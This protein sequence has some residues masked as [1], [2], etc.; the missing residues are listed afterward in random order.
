[1]E[2]DASE[3]A[4]CLKQ[5]LKRSPGNQTFL[6][7]I[8]KVVLT[9]IYLRELWT[10]VAPFLP[11]DSKNSGIMLIRITQFFSCSIDVGFDFENCDKLGGDE[12]DWCSSDGVD[13]ILSLGFGNPRKVSLGEAY[14]VGVYLS[15]QINPG[16]IITRHL[17][18]ALMQRW[19][20][21][22]QTLMLEACAMG[23]HSTG[24]PSVLDP[25]QIDERELHGLTACQKTNLHLSYPF[26][27]KACRHAFMIRE[28]SPRIIPSK[29]HELK[30][31]SNSGTTLFKDSVQDEECLFEAV[32][33]VDS[34]QDEECLFEAVTLVNV[35]NC[36]V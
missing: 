27:K 14:G 32:T 16:H 19:L 8:S 3:M 28:T 22:S 4:N 23:P 31:L 2:G 25:E 29:S 34:V 24:N 6:T 9:D 10:S 7:P 12:V 13:R 11:S 26:R 30:F 36:A 18:Y 20:H 15:P 35:V 21:I 33:L 17:G 1:M 5:I